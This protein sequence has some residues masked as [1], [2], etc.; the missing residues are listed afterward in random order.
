V[1]SSLPAG[2]PRRPTGRKPSG[3]PP[4]AVTGSGR[5]RALD[6]SRLTLVVVDDVKDT[7]A[8][9]ARYLQYLGIRVVTAEDGFA[10]LDVVRTEAPDA[11]VLDLAMPGMTGWEA[12]RRLREDART[13]DLPVIVVSG[14]SARESAVEA[15][16]DSYL[17]KPCLPDQLIAEVLRVLHA[18]AV[19]RR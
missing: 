15:G 16:A 10:A 7:R 12:V 4:S 2:P 19:R 14:Q 5:G 9:Y 1:L 11:V 6:R 8:M 17:E 13:R 18:R 3:T